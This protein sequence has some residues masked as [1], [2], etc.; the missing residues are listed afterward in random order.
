MARKL[1]ISC[2]IGLLKSSS[3]QRAQNSKGKEIVIIVACLCATN[4][5]EGTN[6]KKTFG[7]LIV[8]FNIVHPLLRDEESISHISNI[9]FPKRASH[10]KYSKNL[11]LFA[12]FVA[13]LIFFH[14]GNFYEI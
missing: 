2:K 12:V 10:K 13:H 5:E 14:F 6:K 8:A 7:R 1:K 4:I 3:K 11:Q 9:S